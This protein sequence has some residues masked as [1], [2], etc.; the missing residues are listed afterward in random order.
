LLAASYPGLAWYS[1]RTVETR[2]KEYQKRMLDL[3][4][5][6]TVVSHKY[7]RGIYRSSEET[8][9]ELFRAMLATVSA[10]Q[11]STGKTPP[12]PDALRFT[13]RSRIV[14]GP[15]P[16]FG[17]PALA[18]IETEF[19]MDE[20]IKKALAKV[21]G[22]RKPIEIS[23]RLEY[24]G[25]G[26]TRYSSPAFDR[27]P[28]GNK[29]ET[30]SWKGF[31][32]NMEF[33]RDLAWF[34]LKG[35][36]PGMEGSS[37]D[38]ESV[39]LEQVSFGSNSELAFEDLYIG[40]GWM[41]IGSISVVPGSDE[42]SAARK[43][44]TMNGFEYSAKLVRNKDFLDANG[45]FAIA[46]MDVEDMP[47]KDLHYDLSLNHLHGPTVAALLRDLRKVLAQGVAA[48]VSENG[49]T[50]DQDARRLGIA[51]LERE[52]E[53]VVDRISFAIPD[54]D[55]RLSGRMHLVGFEA[56]DLEAGNPMALV[57]KIDAKVDID[58]AEGLL[59]KFAEKS[60]GAA[61]LE[62]QL[63]ALETQGYCTRSDGRVT[64]HIE[65]RQGALTFNGKAFSPQALVPPPAPQSGAKPPRDTT[66]T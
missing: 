7:D 43:N 21:F 16:A 38:G 25:D 22:D 37:P 10:A 41:K 46:G 5:Y 57:Q 20:S 58:I 28:I 1:G 13:V 29:G 32:A 51:L 49:A 3:A 26:S 8:T 17:A 12:L 33:G 23:T 19:V 45:K 66:H 53:L 9:Y 35:E 61:Q 59:K 65:F 47:I 14:H 63:S 39:K 62:Q 55:A 15:F 27:F 56:A 48:P 4:P 44:M 34:K 50:I 36:A 11:A 24:G 42:A 18:R 2:L 64:T 30:L 40:D 60:G 6:I 31:T 52:P 54:G